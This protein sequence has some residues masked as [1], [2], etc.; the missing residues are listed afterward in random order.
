MSDKTERTSVGKL[1]RELRGKSNLIDCARRYGSSPSAWQRYE[2]GARKIPL[3]LY[4]R[5]R[6][7]HPELPEIT[8]FTQ[9]VV[10]PGAVGGDNAKDLRALLQFLEGMPAHEALA[11]LDDAAEEIERQREQVRVAVIAGRAA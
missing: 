3:T 6:A 5:L 10:P 8:G 2:T 11:L 7:E 9:L 4:L 1:M